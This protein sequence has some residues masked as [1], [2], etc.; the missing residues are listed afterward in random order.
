MP[1]GIWSTSHYLFGIKP[2]VSLR[3]PS[4]S[5][6]PSNGARRLATL[7]VVKRNVDPQ[8]FLNTEKVALC[9]KLSLYDRPIDLQLF[10]TLCDIVL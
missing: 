1:L 9:L 2:S 10:E 7:H 3:E 4:S 5:R 6:S 8:L